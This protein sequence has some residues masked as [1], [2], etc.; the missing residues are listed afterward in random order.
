MIF[1]EDEIQEIEDTQSIDY[2]VF[3]ERFLKVIKDKLSFEPKY[4]NG[5]YIEKET[6]E[7][8]LIELRQLVKRLP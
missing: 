4:L 3:E 8:F 7:E 2:S 5:T 1:K 6:A